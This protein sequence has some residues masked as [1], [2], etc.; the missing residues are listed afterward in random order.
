MMDGTPYQTLKAV[1]GLNAECQV[2]NAV[3]ES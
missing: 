2:L 1:S 3:V